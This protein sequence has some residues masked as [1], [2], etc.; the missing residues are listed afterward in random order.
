[1]LAEHIPTRRRLG[2]VAIGES[3]SERTA[4]KAE[5]MLVEGFGR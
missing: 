3:T 1:V 2:F 4:T 5:E